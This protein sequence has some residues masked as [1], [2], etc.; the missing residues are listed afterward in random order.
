MA[1]RIHQGEALFE[2]LGG[3]KHPPLGFAVVQRVR[4]NWREG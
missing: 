4:L 2:R 1:S 3:Y